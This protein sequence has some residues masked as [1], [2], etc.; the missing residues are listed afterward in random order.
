M[1]MTVS[2][3]YLSKLLGLHRLQKHLTS[4]TYENASN[5]CNK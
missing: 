1:T 3:F 2:N 5:V 4:V